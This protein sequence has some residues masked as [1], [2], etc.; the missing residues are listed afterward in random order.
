MKGGGDMPISEAKKKAN[1]KWNKAN[2]D[3]IQLVVK[4]GV[5][6]QIKQLAKDQGESLN[7]YIFEAVKKRAKEES[8]IDI[9]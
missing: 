2:L 4:K 3:R 1:A 5:R 9:I 7:A 6:E 8:N